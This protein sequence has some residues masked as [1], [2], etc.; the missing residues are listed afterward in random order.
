MRGHEFS[1]LNDCFERVNAYDNILQLID[2]EASMDRCR[3]L[4]ASFIQELEWDCWSAMTKEGMA[5]GR[6]ISA[7]E[8][9]LYS[10]EG[11]LNLQPGVFP[12]LLTA[13]G[14]RMGRPLSLLELGAGLGHAFRGLCELPVID[15]DL[16]RALTLPFLHCDAAS[17]K[18][19]S[20]RTV[21]KN[22][23]YWE[24]DDPRQIVGSFM[25]LR[26]VRRFDCV[27]SVWSLSEYHPLGP[28]FGM[29]QGMAALEV[30]GLFVTDLGPRKPEL[31]ELFLDRGILA[32]LKDAEG[33]AHCAELP[34]GVQTLVR[35]PS[36][37]ESVGLLKLTTL[38]S[39]LED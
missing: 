30:G 11:C 25:H 32:T 28:V 16:S 13:Q 26:A 34:V 8:H 14:S 20:F 27:L 9:S 4:E 24:W 23:I 7:A 35:R 19:R 36:L 39:S 10:Y 29:L 5:V 6:E 15:S 2:S 3:P 31:L 38:A 21:T 1:G 33:V 18:T 37:E 17:L 12:P 22:D